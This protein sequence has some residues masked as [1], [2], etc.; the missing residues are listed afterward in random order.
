MNVFGTRLVGC[1]LLTCTLALGVTGLTGC[2]ATADPKPEAKA[3]SPDALYVRLGG[4]DGIVRLVDAWVAKLG[5]D[6]KVNTRFANTDMA[7]LKKKLVAQ[8]CDVSGGPQDY[9]GKDMKTAHKGMNISET[10]WK[11]FID[12][13]KAT[14]DDL[15]VGAVEREELLVILNPMKSNVVGQ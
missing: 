3:V 4:E 15:K 7:G 11:A 12:D 2:A 14:M 10:E 1:A 5:A 8:L 6:K 9:L 13:L